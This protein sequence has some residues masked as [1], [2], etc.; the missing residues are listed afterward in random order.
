MNV[1]TMSLPIPMTNDEVIATGDKMADALA[2]LEAVKAEKKTAVAG[3][4]KRINAV[5][6]EFIRDDTGAVVQVRPASP[7]DR[8]GELS[9]VPPETAEGE[10]T[11]AQILA[12]NP[13]QAEAIRGETLAA[14]AAER[15]EPTAAD[16]AEA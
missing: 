8:Q 7:T 14:E 16:L 6:A 4:N 12:F 3:F 9:L 1:P 10:Q 11:E 13:E 5:E 2:R 15:E